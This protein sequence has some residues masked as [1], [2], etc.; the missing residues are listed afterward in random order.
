MGK[1][2]GYGKETFGSIY[3]EDWF[4]GVFENGVLT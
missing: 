2:E 3:N 4:E 1:R